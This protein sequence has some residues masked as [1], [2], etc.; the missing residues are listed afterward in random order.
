MSKFYDVVVIGSGTAG[1]SAAY[2]LNR[3]G[4]QVAL[5]EHSQRPGGTCALRGCQA[6]KWFYEGA[7][8]VARSRDLAG[9][10]ISREAAGNWRQLRDAK[11]RFTQEVPA[12]TVAGLKE[13]GIDYIEGR[14]RFTGPRSLNVDG[15]V[16]DA[17]YI[18]VATG[19]VPMEL[20]MEGADLMV[21]SDAFL[22]LTHLPPRIVFIGG[23]FVS[24]EFAHFAV[25]LGPSECR[26]TILE[27][28]PRPLGPFDEE[29]VAYLTEAS[30]QVG[31]EVQSNV[32]VTA[33][34][35]SGSAYA[36]T[37][38]EGQRFE[39]D[40]VVHGAGRSPD[41]DDLDL[42]QAGVEATR[43]GIR[44][45][46]KMT[47][48][49]P[50]VYAVGDCAATIQLARVADAEAQV[51]AE[52][53]AGRIAGSPSAA[54]MDY[55]AVP[56]VLF[57]YPQYAMVGATEKALEEKGVAYRKS[58]ASHLTWPTYQRVGMTAAAY[59]LL[60]DPNGK[61]LGAHIISDN[62]TG[63]VNVCALAMINQIPV[64]KLYRQ[65][66]MT[67]YPSRESDIIYMLKS[68]IG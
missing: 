10:G 68:L 9:I 19:A 5:V 25:R 8:S 60:A 16:L 54:A 27:A 38:A 30:G 61:L 39:T 24:F 55:S 56:A 64:D 17:R 1:Q 46:D 51:A 28:G 7:E 14:A 12:N 57:S 33:I 52:A 65:S 67:P 62:A 32:E 53:I 42:G 43:G 41:I 23:G 20:P 36:V 21:D 34:R 4:L 3:N 13:A 29:M 6:K 18:V 58:A 59:K 26:C 35:K 47:T 22:E 31:I 49:N 63:L 50:R 15:E 45:D 40:L 2:D 66:I 11:N 44:V 48:T 37:T